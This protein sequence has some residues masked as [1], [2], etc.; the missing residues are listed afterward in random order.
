VPKYVVLAD[1]SPDI[2]PSANARTRAR[3]MEGMGMQLPKLAEEAG[4]KFLVEPLHL[5]PSHRTVAVVE[6]PSIEVVNNLLLEVG[7]TQWNT[8]EVS[9][10][11]PV[12]ELMAR[13]E[14][15]PVVYD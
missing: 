10:V 3:A 5:D 6:A 4:M 11:T 15:F 9:A 12:A 8:V 13:V 2:C 7:L 14:D 1:H